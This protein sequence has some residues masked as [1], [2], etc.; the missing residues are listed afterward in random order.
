MAKKKAAKAKA[1]EPTFEQSLEE[2]EAVVTAL[3]SGELGLDQA[4]ERYESG[5]TSLR[6]CHQQLEHA[7][8]R[9]EVLSGFDADGNPV[10]EPLDEADTPTGEASR[11][12]KRSRRSAGPKTSGVDDSQGLF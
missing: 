10:T 4:L 2:L 9:I 8:R 6:R 12:A 3:E 7:E 1:E 5:V 11:T